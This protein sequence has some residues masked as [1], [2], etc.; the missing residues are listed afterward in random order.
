MAQVFGEQLD[1]KT[2]W[3]KIGSGLKSAATKRPEGGDS[4]VA[5]ALDHVVAEAGKAAANTRLAAVLELI[6]EQDEEWN[7][8]WAAYIVRHATIVTAHA[9]AQW[10]DMKEANN[11]K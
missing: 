8:G 2:L 11:A 7:R 6:G 9:R 3:E 1:R 5:A 10:Q 4:L